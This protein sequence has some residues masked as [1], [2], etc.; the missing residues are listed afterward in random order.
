MVVAKLRLQPIREKVLER[1]ET[2]VTQDGS[3]CD[4]QADNYPLLVDRASNHPDL[5]SHASPRPPQVRVSSLCQGDL[6]VHLVSNACQKVIQDQINISQEIEVADK[7][8]SLQYGPPA[9]HFLS[10][11]T[12]SL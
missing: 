3:F 6:N 8:T 7:T 11:T 12:N 9:G 5:H 4:F 1:A 10:P 2:S